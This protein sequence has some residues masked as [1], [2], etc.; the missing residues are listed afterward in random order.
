[1]PPELFPTFRKLAYWLP[2]IPTVATIC[3]IAIMVI[4]SICRTR[5]RSR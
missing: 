1:M 2:L 3:F 5:W 4:W